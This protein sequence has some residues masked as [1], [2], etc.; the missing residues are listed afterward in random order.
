M[1]SINIW[2]SIDSIYYLCTNLHFYEIIFQNIFLNSP[3]NFYTKKLLCMADFQSITN[4]LAQYF[5]SHFTL[6]KHIIVKL[7]QFMF[8]T[9]N[10][11]AAWK[12]LMT[13]FICMLVV[14]AK[15]VYIYFVFSVFN[16]QAPIELSSISVT[17]LYFYIIVSGSSRSF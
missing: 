13:S 7:I 16:Y 6:I 5:H 11:K 12:C 14:R 17:I 8:P 9:H 1:Y 15:N 4:T 2:N 10:L 3:T